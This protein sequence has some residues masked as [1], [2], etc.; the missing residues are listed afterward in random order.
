MRGL[1][2]SVLAT[3]TYDRAGA[4]ISREQTPPELSAE[5]IEPHLRR[6]F[7][8]A[9]LQTPPPVSGKEKV[10]GRPAYQLARKQM[11]LDLAPVE[12]RV[13]ELSLLGIDGPDIYVRVHCSAGTYVRA[14][15]HDL[16]RAIGCGAHL[17]HLR[18]IESGDFSIDSARSIEALEEMALA[19]S[20]SEAL[21]PAARLLPEF[22]SEYVDQIVEGH[23]RQ[24]RDFPVS[25]F[26][27]QKD[28]PY[29]KAI[30]HSGDL[31]AIG[32]IRLPNLYHPIVVL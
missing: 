1:S 12:V 10:G 14:I 23:I 30:S 22:P 21:I 29:V 31:I 6:R 5:M 3:D 24:G 18:R 20:L 7:R 15:A 25:P 17:Y 27:V 19:G 2:A 13:Y 4:P 26:R 9:L 16:G 28:A 11:P 32:E 8:G